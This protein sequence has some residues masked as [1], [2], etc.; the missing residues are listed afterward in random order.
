MI[1]KIGVFTGS[2]S[3]FGLLF[4][5]MRA[6]DVDDRLELCTIVGGAHNVGDAF[7]VGAYVPILRADETPA[8]T[9][10]AIGAGVVDLANRFEDLGLD[11]LIVYGDRFEAFA[12]M[13]ASTQMGLL[14]AHIEGGDLTQG[15]TLDDVVR[16]AMSK[17]AHIH[18]PTNSEAA[19][20]LGAL[21]EE[22][23]RI[24][25]TGF[26]PIDLIEE[27]DFASP[28]EVVDTLGIDKNRPIVLFTQHPISTSP[29]TAQAEISICMEALRTAQRATDAQVILTYP[30]GDVGSAAIIAAL[31][32]F[33]KETGAILRETLGRHLY[34]GVLNICGWNGQGVCVGNSSS[35]LKETPAFGCPAVDIG[36]RQTGRLRGINVQHVDCEVSQIAEA[37]Q[38]G[39]KDRAYR[40]AIQAAPNPYGEGN[41]GPRIAQIISEIDLSDPRLLQKLTML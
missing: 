16:H 10:R 9:P 15:G 37:I 20:R 1:R 26:P 23:W 33:Q 13:I 6:I 14:T 7:P 31:D 39:I 41:T 28:A 18:F 2:R 17:L 34:H 12:A 27:G 36:P 32:A 4:P 40:D 29:E 22:P 21:G 25:T 24:H 8:S 38:K 35:G 3:E 19:E 5:V 30:N 11:A